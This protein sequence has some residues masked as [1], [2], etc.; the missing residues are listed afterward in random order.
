MTDA[1]SIYNRKTYNT[2]LRLDNLNKL[3]SK[4]DDY[5]DSLTKV[6]DATKQLITSQPFK[7]PYYYRKLITLNQVIQSLDE[8]RT[9]FKVL[10]LCA[11]VEGIVN[12]NEDVRGKFIWTTKYTSVVKKFRT[13]MHNLKEYE[14]VH[15]SI[16]RV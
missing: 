4:I 13:F 14:F 2:R 11:Y 3:I 16:M 8:H 10:I 15:Q 5:F 7:Q 6:R 9:N 1:V 12:I